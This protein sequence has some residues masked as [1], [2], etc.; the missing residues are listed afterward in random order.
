MLVR[1]YERIGLTSPAGVLAMACMQGGARC[2]TGSPSGD[3]IW[4]NRNLVRDRPGRMG[5]RGGS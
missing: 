1:E 2:N 4:I 5:C 3:R